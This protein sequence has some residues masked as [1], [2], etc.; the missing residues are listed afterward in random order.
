[1]LAAFSRTGMK[2]PRAGDVLLLNRGAGRPNRG[3]SGC[4]WASG[5]GS[6]NPI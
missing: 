6:A 4:Q 5:A 1:M 3:V 2:C